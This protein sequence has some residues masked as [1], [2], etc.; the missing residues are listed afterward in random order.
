MILSATGDFYIQRLQPFFDEIDT[1]QFKAFQ[2]HSIYKQ[3][4][5][6]QA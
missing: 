3:D 4:Q 6:Y 2:E 5:G 1:R